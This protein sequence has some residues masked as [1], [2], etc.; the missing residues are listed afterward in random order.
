L[1]GNVAIRA[2]ANRKLQY[3]GE[4]LEITNF[5]DANKLVNRKYRQGWEL[6]V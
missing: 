5:P 2:L 3:D 4:N 6:K 1:L